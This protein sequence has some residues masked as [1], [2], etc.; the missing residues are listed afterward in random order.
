MCGWPA[1]CAEPN[2]PQDSEIWQQEHVYSLK[3]LS[4]SLRG[5]CEVHLYFTWLLRTSETCN[6]SRKA[7]WG[8]FCQPMSKLESDKGNWT[9]FDTRKN[10]QTF[11]CGCLTSPV[12]NLFCQ[13]SSWKPR[14]CSQVCLSCAV[15]CLVLGRWKHG[16]LIWKQF[17][18]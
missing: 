11:F 9:S 14:L 10:A 7:S 4:R 8:R 6:C 16:E 5:V 15:F 12:V 13:M 2:W 17:S 18:N 1:R 3:L